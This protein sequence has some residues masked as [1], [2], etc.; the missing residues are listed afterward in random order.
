VKLVR[1]ATASNEA[2]SFV[3]VS[4]KEE[5]GVGDRL[6]PMPPTPIL[7]YVP[8]PPDKKMSARVV[9]IYGGVDQAGQS[10]VVAINRGKMHGIDL[11]TVLELYSHGATVKDTVE[12]KRNIKLPDER[13]GTLFVFRVFDRVSYAL[14][15][16]VTNSVKVG[17]VARSPE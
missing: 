8:H 14:I 7:N 10:Q 2:H 3:V 11:G 9:S 1:E 12:G 17:D 16:Q 13:F 6:L 5:M 15:M 4:S